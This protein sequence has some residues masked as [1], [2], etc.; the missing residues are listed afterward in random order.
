M[1]NVNRLF[2]QDRLMRAATGLTITGFL[3]L[4]E[5]FSK[6]LRKDKWKRYQQG[7]LLGTRKRKPGGGK[8]GTLKTDES[9]LLF[10]LLYFKCYPTM[11]I[12]GIIFNLDRSNVQRN[13]QKLTL[14]LEKTLGKKLSLPKRRI[15]SLKEFFKA[16]PDIKDAFING[17]ERPIQRPKH[18]EKQKR[19]Y[20]GKKKAHTKKNIIISDEKNK[21][22][23]LSPTAAGKKHDYLILKEEISPAVI[24]KDVDFWLDKGF[25]GLDKDYPDHS[26]IIPKRKPKGKDLTLKE[27]KTNKIIS[28]IRIKAEHIIGGVKMLRI[29][30]DKFR[31]KSDKFS[32]QVMNISCKLWNYQ[33]EYC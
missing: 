3:E 10:I 29:V 27:Q 17:T 19:H 24:P 31:N 22:G 28:S 12:L 11:D 8:K 16:F 9:K 26:W 4:L 14:I 30:A 32:D 1:I 13:I 18:Q 33:L 20:S 21:I 23:Y 25:T 2:S 7:I 5:T 6:V 15:S